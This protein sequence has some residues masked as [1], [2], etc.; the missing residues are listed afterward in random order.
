MSNRRLT[1]SRRSLLNG[2]VGAAVVLGLTGSTG[3]AEP[4]PRSAA[5]RRTGNDKWLR[6][7]S[8]NIHH[9]ASPDDVLD[10]ERIARRIEALNVDVIGL[11]EVDRFWKRSDHVDQPAWL[12][13]RLGLHVAF[14]LNELRRSDGAGRRREYGT[15]ILSRWPIR[16][17]RNVALPRWDDHAR[18]GLLRTE[19]DMPGGSLSFATTHLIHAHHDEERAAQAKAVAKQFADD[20]RRS[21]VVG[22]FNDEPNTPA[23]AAMTRRFTDAWA[24]AGSGKGY[25]YSST[26]PK[27]RIDYVFGSEDLEPRA[28][29]V[30]DTDPRASD[31]LPILTEFEL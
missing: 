14:G 9:G 24:V 8:F 16:E 28:M 4:F 7:A 27:R 2:A 12:S 13:R 15:A 20:A 5:D 19:I 21:V 22:D 1:W 18:H 11:Q 25:S 10:L 31:H 26:K 3:P 23:I 29:T 30:D 6:A 17:T